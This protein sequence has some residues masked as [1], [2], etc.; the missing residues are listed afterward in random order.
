MIM[1]NKADKCTDRNILFIAFYVIS[2]VVTVGY[3]MRRSCLGGS[4]WT[5]GNLFSRDFKGGRAEC[6]I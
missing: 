5:S 1:I 4:D 2:V 6:R 3:R